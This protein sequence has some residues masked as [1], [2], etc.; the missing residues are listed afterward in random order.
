MWNT[1]QP[2][3]TYAA[4]TDVFVAQPLVVGNTVYAPNSDT[5]LYALDKT[6][7]LVWKANGDHAIWSTPVTDGKL[8]Y[9]ASMDHHVYAFKQEN[10]S[11]VWK[12]DD[13]GG[14][15]VG[16]PG[17][18]PEE[19]DVYR[20]AGLERGSPWMPPVEAAS[21]RLLWQTPAEGLGLG[22]SADRRR[23]GDL[24]RPGR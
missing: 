10:G 24:Q 2:N 22:C 20:H 7:A 13:L 9:A 23:A 3:W 18:Q 1:R 21:G 12:S 17:A 14:A 15:L 8:I 4:A 19:C 11:Q 16:E 6:G 5:T